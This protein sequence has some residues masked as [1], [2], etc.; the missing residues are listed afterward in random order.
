M[1]PGVSMRHRALS[2]LFVGLLPLGADPLGDLRSQL[3]RWKGQDAVKARVDYAFWNRSGTGPT[4]DV[5]QGKIS[6]GVEDGPSGLRVTWS[7][8]LLQRAAE[9]GRTPPSQSTRPMPT[10]QALSSLGPLEVLE[11]LNAAESLMQLLEQSTLE[12]VR[13]EPWQGK[14]ARCLKL[15]VA[16]RLGEREK[17]YVKHFEGS[18]TLWVSPEGLPLALEQRTTLKGRAFMLLSFEA[19]TKETRTFTLSGRRLIATQITRES[20]GHGA[21]EQNQRTTQVLVHLQDPGN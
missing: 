15:K 5:T 10:R 14:P 12:D 3:D 20:S 19:Q 13:N 6:V 1:L 7:R 11:S 16:P 8:P 4:A 9:E 17:K 2:L 18:A 21:G